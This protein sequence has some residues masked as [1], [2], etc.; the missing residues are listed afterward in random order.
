[1]A[2][3]NKHERTAVPG[4]YGVNTGTAL[5]WTLKKYDIWYRI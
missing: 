4:F 1:M 3:Q 2:Q 5:D